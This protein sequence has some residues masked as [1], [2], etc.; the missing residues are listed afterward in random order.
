MIPNFFSRERKLRLQAKRSLLS[1]SRNKEKSIAATWFL[2]SFHEKESYDCK[3]NEAQM[4]VWL[5]DTFLLHSNITHTDM[6]DCKYNISD[7]FFSF[8]WSNSFAILSLFIG[9]IA[10][11]GWKFRS[12]AIRY[13]RGFTVNLRTPIGNEIRGKQVEKRYI[14]EQRTALPTLY[15]S[16]YASSKNLSIGSTK[17]WLFFYRLCPVELYS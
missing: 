12:Q 11:I 2:T 14:V 13:I 17:S 3:W 7:T 6:S 1:I 15:A 8:G 4:A 10:Y 16:L 9:L 5:W